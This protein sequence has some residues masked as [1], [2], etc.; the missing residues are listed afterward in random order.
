MK[1]Q[2]PLAVVSYLPVLEDVINFRLAVRRLQS[3]GGA[4]AA[5]RVLGA[6]LA[7]GGVLLFVWQGGGLFD[8]AAWCLL[9]LF[10]L[11]V[12]SYTDVLAPYLVRRRA[13]IQFA[14]DQRILVAQT[15]AFY[16]DH[17]TIHTDRYDARLPYG[18]VYR[19]VEDK[20]QFLLYTG[21]DEVRFIPKRVLDEA[22][23][24]QLAST[25]RRAA[26][27]CFQSL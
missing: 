2:Q 11:F 20:K 14:E 5:L 12:A 22:Q 25:L 18:L 15:A 23:C 10:G 7:V 16:E 1:E 8:Q 26:G 13:R 21:E 19:V 6:L 24:A 27:P 4:R 3:S 17:C 9:L